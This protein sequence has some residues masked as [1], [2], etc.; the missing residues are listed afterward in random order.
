MCTAFCQ[1][2]P[3]LDAGADISAEYEAA[4]KL[5]GKQS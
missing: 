3:A 1:M 4:L 2:D 5:Q